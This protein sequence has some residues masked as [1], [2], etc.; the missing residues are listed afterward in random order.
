MWGSTSECQLY[1]NPLLF[2]E[3][4]S[5]DYKPIKTSVMDL[6]IKIDLF[7]IL[8]TRS[9]STIHMNPKWKCGYGFVI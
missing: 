6:K 2:S 4:V 5:V 9:T 8:V 7:F 3:F 1:E